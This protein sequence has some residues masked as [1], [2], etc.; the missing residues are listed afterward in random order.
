MPNW[1]IFI[2]GICVGAGITCFLACIALNIKE[3]KKSVKER[4]NRSKKQD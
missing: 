4:E 2:M 3:D 1:L